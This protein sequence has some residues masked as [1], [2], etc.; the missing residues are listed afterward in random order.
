MCNHGVAGI[1]LV[2]DQHFQL[3]LCIKRS[4]GPATSS[5]PAGE[6][7]TILSIDDN[8]SPKNSSNSIPVGASLAKTN[9]R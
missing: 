1:G 8:E 5:L 9:P 6:R 2:F 4:G 3:H 7:S